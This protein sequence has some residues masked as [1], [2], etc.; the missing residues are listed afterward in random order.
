M[1][2]LNIHKIFYELTVEYYKDRILTWLEI[3]S[4]MFIFIQLISQTN[5]AASSGAYQVNDWYKSIPT[6]VILHL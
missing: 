1:V 4:F 6:Y 2:N 5:S 3:D